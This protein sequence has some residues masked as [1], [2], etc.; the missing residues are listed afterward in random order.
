MKEQVQRAVT[1]VTWTGNLVKFEIDG[2]PDRPGTGAAVFE[3]LANAG[4]SV[5]MISQSSTRQGFYV[6]SFTVPL[7]ALEA[8]AKICRDVAARLGADEVLTDREVAMIVLHGERIPEQPGIAGMAFRATAEM[9][10][11]IRMIT[12][13][14]SSLAILVGAGDLQRVLDQLLPVFK[15]DASE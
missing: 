6:L 1:D 7:D 8:T 10:V 9:D 11:N 15:P 3:A 5:S 4:I 14:D 12:S 2:I 13:A